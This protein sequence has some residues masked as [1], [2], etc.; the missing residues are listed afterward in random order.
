MLCQTPSCERGKRRAVRKG[1]VRI[2]GRM[3]GIKGNRKGILRGG[4][5]REE[6]KWVS[7]SPS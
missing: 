7:C 6:A 2:E 4:M 1:K 5:E 3:V